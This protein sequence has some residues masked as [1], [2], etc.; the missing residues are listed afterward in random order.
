MWCD[1]AQ[2]VGREETVGNARNL[3]WVLI[4]ISGDPSRRNRQTQNS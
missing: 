1:L 3:S 4:S 2:R